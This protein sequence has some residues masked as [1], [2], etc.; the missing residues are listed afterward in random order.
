MTEQLT[1]TSATTAIEDELDVTTRSLARF[2]AEPPEG[3]PEA[4]LRVIESAMRTSGDGLPAHVFFE[5][6]EQQAVATSIT[7]TAGNI[8]YANPAFERLTG[9]GTREV[10]GSNE[11][12]LSDKAT[13]KERYV[14]LWQTITAGRTWTGVLVNRR[15]NGERYLA[16]LTVLPVIGASGDILY[17]LG[18]HRDITEVHRLEQNLRNQKALVET[19]VD[20]APVVVV[21]LDTTGRV[22]VDNHAYKVLMA[23]MRGRE[24]VDEILRALE[25]ILG[26]DLEEARATHREF[27]NFEV[28]IDAGGAAEPRWFSCSGTW[29]ERPDTAIEEYFST[30]ARGGLLLVAN[31]TT[32][33]RKRF[34]QGKTDMVRALMAEQHMVQGMR[35]VLSAA[36]FKLQGPL[37]QLA[38]MRSMM[39]KSE[40][41]E[42]PAGTALDEVLRTGEEALAG[43]RKAMPERRAEAVEPVNV[44]EIIRDVLGVSVERFLKEGVVVDWKP[45]PVLP[46]VPARANAL[47]TLIK[48]LLDNAIDAFREPG[49]FERDVQIVTRETADGLVQLF[50]E[51]SGP[52]I[53]ED[54]RRTVFEPFFSGWKA[55]PGR[56]GM[57]LA[58]AQQVMTDQGG[59]IAIERKEGTGCRVR[60]D[61]AATPPLWINAGEGI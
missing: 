10:I 21:L 39:A 18:M 19:V 45:Q 46:A 15:K 48:I 28:R 38:A 24:P 49:S 44:N 40:C 4:V 37:N 17:Y 31:E 13:P 57:G 8:L 27:A 61:F 41:L 59:T 47:R 23:D 29:V 2:L 9:Y 34:E 35:E 55:S 53:P 36:L 32:A 11:S 7:D 1:D 16:D 22:I 51:D 33:E 50:I 30:N 60:V 12:I 52:G 56:A 43:L 42:G 5:A 54:R 25:P 6:V 20:A 14:D 58:V 26:S 3:T